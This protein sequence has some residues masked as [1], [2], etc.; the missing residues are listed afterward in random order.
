MLA[1]DSDKFWPRE[2]DS[3]GGW[4]GTTTKPNPLSSG[5][6]RLSVFTWQYV[7]GHVSLSMK[8]ATISSVLPGSFLFSLF[9]F[10][11]SFSLSFTRFN[12][13]SNAFAQCS[14]FFLVSSI[15]QSYRT[16]LLIETPPMSPFRMP[17]LGPNPHL[18]LTCKRKGE[19]ERERNMK[20]T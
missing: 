6:V 13:R 11:N 9:A 14:P 12:H 5:H 4:D 1:L 3:W 19:R 10:W 16:L 17:P 15:V 8:S 2:T 20:R 18:L 7:G